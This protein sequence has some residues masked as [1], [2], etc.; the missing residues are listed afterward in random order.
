MTASACQ[1]TRSRLLLFFLLLAFTAP[2]ASAQITFAPA[3]PF[4]LP[5]PSGQAGCAVSGDFNGDARPDVAVCGAGGIWIFLNKG[6]GTFL[7]PFPLGVSVSGLVADDFNHDGK[8]GIA[9][10]SG[11]TLQVYLNN[12]FANFA[13]AVKYVLPS[14]YA[15]S[16]G[17][18]QT[19]D[20]N[21]DGFRDIA[22]N[23]GLGTT[24][25]YFGRSDG[26]FYLGTPFHASIS[27]SLFGAQ[28]LSAVGD[29]NGDGVDD[30]I[31]NGFDAGFQVFLGQRSGVCPAYRQHTPL[32]S[33]H[34]LITISHGH[35]W[36]WEV[37]Y[38]GR[39]PIFRVL[40]NAE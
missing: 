28:W 36:R 22:V 9:S 32:L 38:R 16:F 37:R 10:V 14:G 8:T 15:T 12:G 17:G 4:V 20:F 19:G 40:C 11:S 23:D 3:L 24:V 31:I 27:N 7:S 26:T 2:H 21:G 25:V 6:D 39:K 18:M 33:P 5:A 29:I 34:M 13:S 1:T 30:F 35:E